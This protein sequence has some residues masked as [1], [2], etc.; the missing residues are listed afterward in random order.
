[1]AG[2][3][4]GPWDQQKT[5]K[6]EQLAPGRTIRK[7]TISTQIAQTTEVV[8]QSIPEWCNNFVDVF[9][10]KTH[11]ILPYDHTIDLKN[12]FTLKITKIYSLNPAEMETF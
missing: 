8:E 3:G 2:S 10:E 7:T 11:K 12:T 6:Q 1:M 5:T 4:C 9:F